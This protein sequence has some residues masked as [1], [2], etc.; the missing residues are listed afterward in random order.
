MFGG[1]PRTGPLLDRQL[2]RNKIS[3]LDLGATEFPHL[4]FG[5]NASD[6]ILGLCE[7]F[8]LRLCMSV[9]TSADIN[10]KNSLLGPLW[11]VESKFECL[12]KSWVL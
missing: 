3:L 7:R 5:L 10:E 6:G 11:L 4:V 12:R 2:Y 9:N 8:E 1:F